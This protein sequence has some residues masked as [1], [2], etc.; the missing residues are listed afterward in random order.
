MYFSLIQRKQYTIPCTAPFRKSYSL[1]EQVHWWCTAFFFLSQFESNIES[2]SYGFVELTISNLRNICVFEEK[3]SPCT[4]SKCVQAGLWTSISDF[5]SKMMILWC[6]LSQFRLFSSFFT[7]LLWSVW[8]RKQSVYVSSL[9]FMSVAVKETISWD[10]L[11]ELLH[12]Q[13]FHFVV[14]SLFTLEELPFLI[15]PILF[16]CKKFDQST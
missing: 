16:F 12:H 2:T 10:L 1:K 8:L 6:W 9:W 5:E 4:I 7:S 13:R 11:N 3:I 15:K 14:S